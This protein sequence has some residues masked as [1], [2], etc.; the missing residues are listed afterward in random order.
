MYIHMASVSSRVKK[1]L[2]IIQ[3]TD[4]IVML[5]SSVLMLY[6]TL[7]IM[8]TAF[9][10]EDDFRDVYRELIT[11]KA[12]YYE[13]GIMLGLRPGDLV[14][15]RKGNDIDQAFTEIILKWLQQNYD[16]RKHGPPTW[17]N[18][19]EAVDDPAGGNNHALA[20]RVAD[21][22]SNTGKVEYLLQ[23]SNTLHFY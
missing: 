19:V 2:V 12:K 5:Y 11:V 10:G 9:V 14:A 6:V 7:V 20:M 4:S 22:H 15:I 16:V 13:L 21:K 18:L 17:R 1:A 8:Y 3:M 23:F